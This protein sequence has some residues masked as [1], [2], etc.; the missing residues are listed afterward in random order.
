MSTKVVVI[1]ITFVPS[2]LCNL[3]FDCRMSCW[4]R[5]MHYQPMV[6]KPIIFKRTFP[7]YEVLV[8]YLVS[9]ELLKFFFRFV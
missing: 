1:Q 7:H 2:D 6:Y 9:A 4:H 8:L 3:M 5:T